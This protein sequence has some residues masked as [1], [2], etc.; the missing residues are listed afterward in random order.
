MTTEENPSKEIELLA[1]LSQTNTITT[2]QT[3]LLTIYNNDTL[4]LLQYILFLVTNDLISE[5]ERSLLVTVYVKLTEN[6]ELNSYLK[7]I[8]Q[9]EKQSAKNV[10]LLYDLIV[11]KNYNKVG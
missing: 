7:L 3:N 2:H 8:W 4:E 9:I 6:N 1:S 10:I 11:R 5:T